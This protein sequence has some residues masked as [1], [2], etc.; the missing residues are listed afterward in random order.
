[1]MTLNVTEGM[2]EVVVPGSIVNCLDVGSGR[3][4]LHVAALNGNMRCVEKL[5]ENGAL[6]HLSNM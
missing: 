4:P 1:M 5:L 2:A 6:V 3:S